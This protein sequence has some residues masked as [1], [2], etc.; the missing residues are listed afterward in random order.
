MRW[1]LKPEIEEEHIKKL[2]DDLSVE[3]TI[4]KILLQRNIKTFEEAKKFFRPSLE[5]LHDPFLMKDMDRAVA[6]IE[7]AINNH[8]NILVFGDY[9]VDGT[10]A[11]SLVSS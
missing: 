2:A 11:V 8:E 4:S 6:R 9:D 3:K 1:S 5:D 7:A 10:T